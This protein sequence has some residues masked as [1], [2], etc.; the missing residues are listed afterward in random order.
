MLQYMVAHLFLYSRLC[1][2][3][4]TAHRS[5]ADGPR[6][7]GQGLRDGQAHYLGDFV[8]TLCAVHGLVISGHLPEPEEEL[9]R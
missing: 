5:Q 7:P 3:L 8:K 1:L 2:W 4:L 9:V 6:L